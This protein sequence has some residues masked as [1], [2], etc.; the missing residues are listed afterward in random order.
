MSSQSTT[1]AAAVLEELYFKDGIAID[2]I[3]RDM[4]TLMMLNH[5][6]D[7][8]GEGWHLPV[9]HVNPQNFAPTYSDA[10]TNA[11]ASTYVKFVGTFPQTVGSVTVDGNLLRVTKGNRTLL[12]NHL[13]AE[14]D[15]ALHEIKKRLGVQLFGNGGGFIGKDVGWVSGNTLT[16]RAGEAYNFEVGQVIQSSTDDGTSGSIDGGSTTVTAVDPDNDQITVANIASLTSWAA[17]D[18]IFPYGY[19]GLGMSGIQGWIP[20][21]PGTFRT[22]D[23]TVNPNRLA[24]SRHSGSSTIHDSLIKLKSKIRGSRTNA[25][26]DVAVLNPNDYGDLLVELEDRKRLVDAAA[27]GAGKFAY[28]SVSGVKVG[29][30]MV[31]E[32]IACPDGTGF[33]LS[34]N[35]WNYRTVGEML[36]VIDED[37]QK[38]L[39]VYN[40]DA[41][42]CRLWT[43][44]DFLCANPGANGRVTLP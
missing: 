26:T 28:L 33:M 19:F 31:F 4:P 42:E 25:T 17:G 9:R 22:V 18:Y 41:F 35:V 37:G 10:N 34:T 7:G 27:N 3:M 16:L 38:F 6:T 14:M 40:S 29:N 13:E 32:D 39:R 21:T 30:T 8:G 12:V 5:T 20:S 23:T 11:T 44:G 2:M 36:Q 1:T 43:A 15:G 24:G